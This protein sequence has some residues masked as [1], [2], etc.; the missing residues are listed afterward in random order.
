[1]N[2]TPPNS[3]SA[4][5]FQQIGWG[6]DHGAFDDEVGKA[7]TR[8]YQFCPDDP[9][10]RRL[11]R[12]RLAPLRTKQAMGEL[13]AFKAARLYNGNVVLG[14]D[15]HGGI[16]WILMA[17][18]RAG[19]LLLANTGGGKTSLLQWLIF[20]VALQGVP[21]WL[22]ESYKTQ[23]R[24]LHGLFARA[25]LELLILRACDWK[26]NPLQCHHENLHLHLATTVD[27]LVRILVLPSRAR[28]ILVQVCHALYRKFGNW[29]GQRKAWPCLFD[30]YEAINQ[31]SKLNAAAREAILDRLGALLVSL[32]PQCAAY[33]SGWRPA[34]LTQFNID[35]EM[36]GASETAKQ[37]LLQ[38]LLFSVFHAEVERG[39][40]NGPLKLVIAFDDAQRFFEARQSESP[41][42]APMDELASI[43]RSTGLSLWVMA[44]TA[45]GLS[46]QLLPNLATKIIGRLGGAEDYAALGATMGLTA[47]QIRWAKLHL[48]PGSFI[49]QC[50]EGDWREP[51][52][53]KVPL[54]PLPDNVDN[55]AA[56]ESLEPLR[57]LPTEFAE[58]FAHWQPHHY[59]EIETSAAPAKST[60]TDAA[61]RFLVAVVAEPGRRSSDYARLTGLSGKRAA[62]IRQELIKAGLLRTHAVATG[63]RGRTAIVL[64]ATELGRTAA[65]KKGATS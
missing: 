30:V 59:A 2:F 18:L 4:S 25:H 46:P 44:Q 37:L 19:L 60:L 16:I 15:A 34:D 8:V 45:H 29:E 12:D 31:N 35:F 64:E 5:L 28:S 52:L 7:L 38:S 63:A 47:D 42:L 10:V 49:G 65:D 62:A 27:L 57:G 1:M 9:H 11:I 58:E 53:F 17:W 56:A 48:S 20:Q 50:S 36:R 33:R 40:V 13:P 24:R 22:S 6:Q 54:L 41:D 14:K 51:F 32:T 3:Q 39:V 26:W 61:Q 43:L 55:V 23:L 21:V